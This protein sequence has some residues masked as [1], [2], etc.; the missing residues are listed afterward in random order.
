MIH[1]IGEI[2][3]AASAGCGTVRSCGPA[4]S[5]P[6][7]DRRPGM[8]GRTTTH[9]ASVDPVSGTGMLFCPPW[10]ADVPCPFEGS[11]LHYGD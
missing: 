10:W 5:H 7:V 1:Q 9:E 4:S 6:R 3:T 8:T 11:S 2:A